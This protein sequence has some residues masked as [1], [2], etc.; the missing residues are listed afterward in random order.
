MVVIRNPYNA[1]LVRAYHNV[2]RLEET[3][4]KYSRTTTSFRGRNAMEF[5]YEAAQEGKGSRTQGEIA[6]YLKITRPSCTTL[7]EKLEGLGYVERRRSQTDERQSDIFLTRK[8]R[9]VT[10]YQSNHRNEMIDA[11]LREFTPEE[12]EIIYRGFQ[13]LNEVLE[14]CID[15]LET[16]ADHKEH[17]KGATE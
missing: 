16:T 14:Q 11:T 13:R 5:I 9:L 12:Q 17:V 4:R 6:E 1:I 3:K 15:T 8:G 10:V 7:M 2:L